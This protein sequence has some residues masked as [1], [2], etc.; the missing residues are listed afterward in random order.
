MN[1]YNWSKNKKVA[2]KQRKAGLKQILFQV[3]LSNPIQDVQ[4]QYMTKFSENSFV[5]NQLVC[6]QTKFSLQLSHEDRDS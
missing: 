6:S 1:R 3:F 2:N 4:D 5:E